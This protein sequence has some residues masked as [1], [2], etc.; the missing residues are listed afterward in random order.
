MMLG[1]ALLFPAVIFAASEPGKQSPDKRIQPLSAAACH[2]P[3][4]LVSLE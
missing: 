2:K 4:K 3:G 1:A